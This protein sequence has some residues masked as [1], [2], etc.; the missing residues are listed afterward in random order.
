[1]HVKWERHLFIN[2]RLKFVSAGVGS[3][4]QICIREW[5]NVD[6][7]GGGGSAPMGNLYPRVGGPGRVFP[8]DCGGGTRISGGRYSVSGTAHLGIRPPFPVL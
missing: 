4:G 6:S 7:V 2:L 1:M 5:G 3:H 8:G